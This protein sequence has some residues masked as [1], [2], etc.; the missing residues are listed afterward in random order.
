MNVTSTPAPES[1]RSYLGSL[2][3]AFGLGGR[4]SS[5]DTAKANDSELEPSSKQPSVEKTSEQ[6][7][8]VDE[9]IVESNNSV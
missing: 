3:N 4:S 6:K 1:R 2:W 7:P 9:I 8:V 5:S